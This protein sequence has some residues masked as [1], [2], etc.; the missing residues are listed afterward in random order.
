MRKKTIL[1]FLFPVLFF[2]SCGEEQQRA[3]F[4]SPVNFRIDLNGFDHSLNNPL[5]YKT[6]TQGRLQTDRVGFG[7]L[8]IVSGVNGEIF[9][10]D[11]AC[12]FE[13]EQNITV[14]P[15]NNGEAVCPS[16]GRVFITMHGFGNERNGR[17][18]LQRYNVV[19]QGGGVFIVR[20]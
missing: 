13:R 2:L 19:S 8:L 5:T 17:L 18:F 16:C 3:I 6:F 15:N 1:C 4:F 20:H 7:G 14:V 11:L 12:P 10:F 9:A